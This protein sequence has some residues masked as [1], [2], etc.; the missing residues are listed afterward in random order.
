MINIRM[1][2]TALFS[3]FKIYTQFSL[4]VERKGGR[5][6]VRSPRE[7][8]GPGRGGN[9]GTDG[10]L[11]GAWVRGHRLWCT[12]HASLG[13][14]VVTF[15]SNKPPPAHGWGSAGP[16]S[17]SREDSEHYKPTALQTCQPLGTAF[18]FLAIFPSENH[19]ADTYIKARAGRYSSGISTTEIRKQLRV[20]MGR[21]L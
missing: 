12:A 13:T 10:A 9:A 5:E 4:G 3:K 21:W 11:G 7:T 2:S 18:P 20:L 8:Q 14:S 16:R 15:Q 19:P 1:S 17:G 6:G